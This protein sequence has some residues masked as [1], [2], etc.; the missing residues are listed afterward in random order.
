MSKVTID[1]S[2]W[3]SAFDS[4]DVFHAASRTFLRRIFPDNLQVIQP[5][6]S[7]LEVACA[8]SRR[9]RDAGKSRRLT[10]RI[11]SR[12]V[13][14]EL[15][16]D[17]PFLSAAESIGTAQFLRAGDAIYAAAAHLASAT[18]ISWDL[19]HIQRASASTPSSW[20]A[21]NP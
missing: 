15:P 13:H 6:F 8:L 5:A 9:L 12:L 11:F 2:V 7:K 4:S 10:H 3:I 21:A 17:L 18:L 16:M 19:E 20:L 14:A 1:A